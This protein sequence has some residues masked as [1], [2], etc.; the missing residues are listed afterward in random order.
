MRR[1]VVM[2]I[3]ADTNTRALNIPVSKVEFRSMPNNV[4]TVWFN[5][6]AEARLDWCY[7]LDIGDGKE[8]I[9]IDNLNQIDFEFEDSSDKVALV[10]EV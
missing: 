3:L 2:V 6:G 9:Y 8:D 5:V 1:S 10:Y 4:G 7:P